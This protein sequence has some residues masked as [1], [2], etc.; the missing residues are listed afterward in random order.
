MAQGRGPRPLL[1]PRAACACPQLPHPSNPGQTY[2]AD[3][4]QRMFAALLQGEV[5]QYLYDYG[6]SLHVLIEVL[7]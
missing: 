2:K 5:F 4:S 1:L 7:C 3:T 6:D